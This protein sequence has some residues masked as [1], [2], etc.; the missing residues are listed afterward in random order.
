MREPH[1]VFIPIMCG[2]CATE[3]AGKYDL[4][5]RRKLRHVVYHSVFQVDKFHDVP[6]FAAKCAIESALRAFDIPYLTR[7]SKAPGIRKIV[8]LSYA[9]PSDDVP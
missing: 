9:P 6:H 5:K 1:F 3:T 2:R 7:A 8:P 4:A